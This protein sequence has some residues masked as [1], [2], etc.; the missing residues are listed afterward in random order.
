MVVVVIEN[1]QHVSLCVFPLLNMNSN[2]KTVY[3]TME[4]YGKVDQKLG[5]FQCTACSMRSLSPISSMHI[6]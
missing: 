1:H 2:K 6:S 5:I 3:R 4:K